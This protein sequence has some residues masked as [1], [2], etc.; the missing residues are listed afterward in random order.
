MTERELQD[1]IVA[2]AR[3]L[4]WR[5][6]HYRA[7]RTAQGWRTPVSYDGRGLPDLLLVRERVVFA[8]IKVGRNRLSQEQATWLEVLRDAGAEAHVWTDAD[9]RSGLVEAELRR[10]S[11]RAA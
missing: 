6:A 8:E 1:W 3:L 7:A 10:E 9:W 4:G 5:V 11:L 2:A